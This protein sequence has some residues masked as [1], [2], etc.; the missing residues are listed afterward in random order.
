MSRT[1]RAGT[2]VQVTTEYRTVGNAILREMI[3]LTSQVFPDRCTRGHV[4]LDSRPRLKPSRTC[5]RGNDPRVHLSGSGLA[6]GSA[7]FW[8]SFPPPTQAFGDKPRGNDRLLGAGLVCH[9][10]FLRK[11]ESTPRPERESISMEKSTCAA[12]RNRSKSAP[13]RRKTPHRSRRIPLGPSGGIPHPDGPLESPA[14][15]DFPVPCY[16]QK[17]F[18][19]IQESGPE[20]TSA[21]EGPRSGANAPGGASPSPFAALCCERRQ[22][23][24]TP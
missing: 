6:G 14:I 5:F 10:S 21:V 24:K 20:R 11:Q 3:R 4:F 15:D 23:E 22:E 19:S 2:P 9:L 13:S 18:Q 12:P 1:D 8:L 17:K 7:W 16:T